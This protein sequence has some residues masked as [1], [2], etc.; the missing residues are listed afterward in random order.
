MQKGMFDLMTF[1]N[2][3]LEYN[4]DVEGSFV[5]RLLKKQ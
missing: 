2:D 3:K 5:K 4:E 1:D